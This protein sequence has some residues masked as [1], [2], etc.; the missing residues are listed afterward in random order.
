E[1][2][3]D[4]ELE[5]DSHEVARPERDAERNLPEVELAADQQPD[6]GDHRA[7]RELRG[8][9]RPEDR[10]R[11]VLV[12]GRQEVRRSRPRDQCDE[13]HGQDVPPE[14][15]CS[16]DVAAKKTTLAIAAHTHPDTCTA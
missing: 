5:G 16:L 4:D 7:D 14:S 2:W 9:R 10:V 15:D 3:P 8:E 13:R 12:Q 1:S 11:I 6:D